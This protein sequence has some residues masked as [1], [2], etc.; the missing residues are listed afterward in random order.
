MNDDIRSRQTELDNLIKQKE[1][2]EI[3]RQTEIER[4]QKLEKDIHLET[5]KVE[6]IYQNF[7]AIISC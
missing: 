4:L 7:I 6:N 5:Q 3:D 2:I 1:S